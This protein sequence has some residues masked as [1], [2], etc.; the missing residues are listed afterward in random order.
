MST[1]RALVK[2]PW[3]VIDKGERK[4]VKAADEKEKLKD[5]IRRLKIKGKIQ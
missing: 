2:V 1:S 5:N 4:K 3:L